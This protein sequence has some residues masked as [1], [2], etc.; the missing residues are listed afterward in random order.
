MNDQ[1]ISTVANV[2]MSKHGLTLSNDTYNR[3][4]MMSGP[5]NTCTEKK[6]EKHNTHQ[7]LEA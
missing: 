5:Q 7:K 1:G 6:H 2:L 3:K 4:E